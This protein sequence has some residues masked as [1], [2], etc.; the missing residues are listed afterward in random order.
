MNPAGWAVMFISVGS[1]LTLVCYCLC[2]VLALPPVEAD[3]Q[4]RD[5]WP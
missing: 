4:E 2:R 1:V 3:A 5:D